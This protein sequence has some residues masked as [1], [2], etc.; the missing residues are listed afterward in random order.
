MFN[1]LD[2][3]IRWGVTVPNTTPGDIVT[4]AREFGGCALRW[5]QKGRRGFVMATGL[6]PRDADRLVLASKFGADLAI[7]VASM[8]PSPS[9]Q[10]R[11]AAWQT[12]SGT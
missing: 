9:R 2:A 8:I 5:Q 6:G 4:V 10:R 7:D 11:P 1:P 3:G 12:W